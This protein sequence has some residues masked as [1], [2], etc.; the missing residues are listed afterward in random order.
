MSYAE[1]R[2]IV[3]SSRKMEVRGSPLFRTVQWLKFTRGN[4]IQWAKNGIGSLA[5]RIVETCDKL[6]D[7]QS[8]IQ[9]LPKSQEEHSNRALLENLHIQE[10]IFWAQ[11]AKTN[12]LSLLFQN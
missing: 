8:H 3:F 12:L 11:R 10:E 5:K 6:S 4:L 7:L 2:E 9:D 1:T